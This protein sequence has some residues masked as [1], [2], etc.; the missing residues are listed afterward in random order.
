MVAVGALATLRRR[1]GRP[2][3]RWQSCWPAGSCVLAR[4]RRRA[5]AAT[6]DRVLEACELMSAELAAGQPPGHALGRAAT[7]W[8][9]LAP[10]ARGVRARR[11][12]RQ[13][14]CGASPPE[15]GAGDL[16]GSLA[17]GWS[18]T[19]AAPGWP[20]RS[21]G[22]PASIR[23]DRATAAGRR[24]RARLGAGHRPARGG[25]PGAGAAPRQR[26]RRA[27]PGRSCCA[28]PVGLLCLA[29]GLALG[30]RRALVDRA[31]RGRGDAL[32]R[33][34]VLRPCACW[35]A[36]ASGSGG[37]PAGSGRRRDARREPSATA[38]WVQRGRRWWPWVALGAGWVCSAGWG[39]RR[40]RRGRRRS[41]S[42]GS[43]PSAEPAEVRRRAG[44]GAGATCRCWCCCSRP[45]CGRAPPPGRR[46]PGRS[47]RSPARR[48]TGCSLTADQLAARGAD[49]TGSGRRWRPIPSSA[50]LGR[51]LA[52][53]ERTGAPVAAV[54]ERL[55]DDLAD[56]RSG[57][58]RGPG[59]G[60]RACGPRS[61]SGS[62]C[63]RASCCSGS[64]PWSRSLV[65]GLAALS[66]APVA[67]HTATGVRRGAPQPTASP[68]AR[69]RWPAR[70]SAQTGRSGRP[71]PRR[72][73]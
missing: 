49:P 8:P 61:R 35:R 27:R 4:D 65:A 11:R 23:A 51:A 41:S 69:G 58:G 24:G 9:L 14:R 47:R 26:R 18:P 33:W 3:R 19:A 62:A 67:G 71:R 50:P 7:S 1:A 54:V 12:R 73:R 53:A 52:R 55:A 43:S 15:P 13:R 32:M 44:A 48:P 40:A 64:C 16:R 21:T 46:P 57:R 20:R 70:G 42:T 63:C 29:G 68:L 38:D 25:A 30:A 36:S 59:P 56:G 66:A 39:R 72:H 28:T 5:A 22:S 2:R 6:A 10:V 17:P 37:G 60:G 31:D 34:G 45:R